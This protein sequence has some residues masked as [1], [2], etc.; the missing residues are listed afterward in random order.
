MTTRH[1]H[2]STT[3]N[4]FALANLLFSFASIGANIVGN[5][6]RAQVD[7]LRA[8]NLR[9]KNLVEA[10][11][12]GQAHNNVLLGDLNVELRLLQIEEKRRKLGLNAAPF[13]ADGYDD[14][15][16]A[17]AWADRQ[18]GPSR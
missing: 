12:V 2:T 16:P 8:E 17:P 1:K 5:Q 14:P 4:L 7:A 9:L 15:L 10:Q 11:R 6:Q 13:K 3:E 18:A